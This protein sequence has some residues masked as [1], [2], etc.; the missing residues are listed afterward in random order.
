MEKHHPYAVKSNHRPLGQNSLPGLLGPRIRQSIARWPGIIRITHQLMGSGN[1]ATSA[2]CWINGN[3]ITYEGTVND[4]A[5]KS[6]SNDGIPAKSVPDLHFSFCMQYR[7]SR[8]TAGAARRTIE[9]SGIDG[10]RVATR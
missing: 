10:H 4:L 6:E 5:V 2:N 3:L 8:R 7:H 1:P 9:F